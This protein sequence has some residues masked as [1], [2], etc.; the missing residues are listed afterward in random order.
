MDMRRLVL[1]CC[2]LSPAGCASS[3]LASD[4][5][6]A[7]P[8]ALAPVPAYRPPLD[9]DASPPSNF[10]DPTGDVTLTEAWRLALM[11]HPALASD[12]WAVREA[13]AR[14]MQA[15]VMPNPEIDFRLDDFAGS[16]QRE[17]FDDANLRVR[18]TQVI[19]LGDKRA[20]RVDLAQAERMLAAWDYEARRVALAADVSGRF[21]R[22]LAAQQRVTLRAGAVEFAQS[23]SQ[24]IEDR[25]KAGGI[26]PIEREHA[27][28]RLAQANIEHDEAKLELEAARRQLAS[29]W[30]SDRAAFRAAVGSLEVD[31]A[32]NT[33]LDRLLARLADHPQVARLAGEVAQR[34]A[35]LKLARAGAVS[36]VTVGV[37]GRYFRDGDDHAL[38][39]EFGFPLPIFDRR[40]GDILEKRFAVA[41]AR[42]AADQAR[43]SARDELIAAHRD[44]TIAQAHDRAL[45]RQVL[46]SL[47]AAF[48]TTQAQFRQGLIKLD[49]MLDAQRDLL[50]AQVE[51]LNAMR[52]Y[53]RA[54]AVV[55]GLIGQPLSQIEA[56]ETP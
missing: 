52:D 21:A 38:L 32:A 49:D 44:M 50:K 36:D 30:N 40:E 27:Q 24:L 14:Q 19:E 28:V 8:R 11:R 31:P 54:A 2:L 33:D 18:L 22:L 45:R 29:C 4:G 42:A 5:D 46:P 25:I 26:L 55:E 37:G 17:G 23:M 16:G 13:E 9:P 12:A 35:A 10:T 51:S 39:V 53:H 43:A 47:R 48:D 34:Q 7:P 15:D 41:R 56:V 1:F 20:R 3:P 6:W